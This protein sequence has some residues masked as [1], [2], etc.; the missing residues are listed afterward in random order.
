MPR[1]VN[2]LNIPGF[3]T[4]R[5]IHRRKS[6]IIK[7]EY[8]D[9]V[10]CPHCEGS[11]LRLKDKFNRKLRHE[12]IGSK[13]SYIE[14][15]SHKYFCELCHKYFNSRLPG[16]LPYKR[17]TER[18]RHEVFQKH[19]DGICKKT[20][21]RRLG[22]GSAT[23]E[24]YTQDYLKRIISKKSGR[25]C[26]QVMG[27][28]EHFFTRKKGYATT[29]CDLKNHKVYDVVL[30]RT[31]KSL[32]DYL[33]KLT[34]K[35]AVKVVV[36]DL[37]ETYRKIVKKHFPNAKIVADRFH[38]IRLINHHF[39]KLWQM[40][41]PG[42]RRNRGLLSLIRRHD[43]NL[44]NSQKEK[45]N[46][47]FTKNKEMKIIYDFKQKLCA[48]ISRK[49]INHKQAKKLIPKLIDY[50]RQLEYSNFNPMKTLAKTMNSW[51]EEIVRMWRFTKTNSIT[52]GFHNKM[53]M[54]SRRAY[55]FRNFENYRL[56][57][58]ALCG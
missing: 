40:I 33:N 23:V 11:I 26:P 43:Y 24:R 25:T 41:D 35:D 48:L 7:V 17:C 44:S 8:T 57:V 10:C 2:I 30:G 34:G 46:L 13:R 29:I 14:F 15:T 54:I 1:L 31:E 16:I 21:G 55:G 56:R 38:V 5:I 28:D 32:E 58:K 3:K 36:M 45:L 20:L 50:I 49:R 19:Q 37:S 9:K 42:G 27:I 51:I 12:S 6:I 22:I 47:Y 18:F 53:E 39:L 52:E 4:S